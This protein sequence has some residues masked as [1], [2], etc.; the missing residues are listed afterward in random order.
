M[1]ADGGVC[2]IQLR[3]PSK[4]DRVCELLRPFYFLTYVDDYHWSNVEWTSSVIHAPEYLTGTYGT[5]QEWNIAEDLPRILDPAAYE[6]EYCV[7]PS[8]TY[9]DLTFIELVED[10]VTRPLS[11]GSGSGWR[12]IEGLRYRSYARYWDFHCRNVSHLEWMLWEVVRWYH[13]D[14][15]K[16]RDRLR[17]IGEMKIKEWMDELRSLLYHDSVGCDETWT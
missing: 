17:H 6:G 9:G 16:L 5:D 14:A 7:D 2:W 15:D 12:Y 11:D 13:A 8:V 1:G 3:D 4:Y 10:L